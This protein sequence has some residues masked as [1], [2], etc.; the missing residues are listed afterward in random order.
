MKSADIASTISR[1][2]S[3]ANLTESDL[4]ELTVM[5]FMNRVHEALNPRCEACGSR[6]PRLSCRECTP[7]AEP[8]HWEDR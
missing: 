1:M 6:Y 8:E 7:A 5:E 4:E 3:M 2:A